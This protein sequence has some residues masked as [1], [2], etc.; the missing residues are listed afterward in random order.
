M[1][2]ASGAE[3]S[4][5]PWGRLGWVLDHLEGEPWHLVSCHGTEERCFAT[6]QELASRELLGSVTLID[7]AEPDGH[8]RAEEMATLKAAREVELADLSPEIPVERL[9][10]RLLEPFHRIVDNTRAVAANHERIVL[11]I[12]A[13][14]KRF[15]FPILKIILKTPS[16]VDV[17]VTYTMAESYAA[18]DLHEDIQSPEFL[19]LF[20]PDMAADNGQRQGLI[21]SV[22][23]ESSGVIQI[24]EA[25]D[26]S[27]VTVLFSY[28]A[29]PP[30]FGRNWDFLRNASKSVD[31]RH[32][33]LKGTSA[34]DVAVVFD[35]LATKV[36]DSEGVCICA[37]FGPKPVS[38][39]M[40]L[41]VIGPG[42]GQSAITYTQPKHYS[43]RY[44]SGVLSDGRGAVIY[45][46][47][48]VLG[49]ERLYA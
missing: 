26:Y 29:P 35:T 45:G 16:V 46:Y 25:N 36:A 3:F 23:F 7:I 38:L 48:V 11:D 8:P 28:P 41:F 24:I 13:L 30:F 20:A 14:P 27:P 5:R 18:G 10:H 43:P 42:S 21:V 1:T 37:P 9:A 32:L 4:A 2:T 39:A 17:L 49:G 6:L 12:T 15:F 19:P 34:I 33:T 44:S 40:A 47:P 22:G 31:P